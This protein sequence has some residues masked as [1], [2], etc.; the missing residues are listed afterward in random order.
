MKKLLFF[1]VSVCI[2]LQVNS[3]VSNDDCVNATPITIPA[4][5]SVCVTGTTANALGT[6]YTSHGCYPTLQNIPDVW[7]TFI[8]TGQQNVFTLSPNG[9]T[10]AQQVGLTISDFPCSSASS[11]ACDMSATNNGT[12][13]LTYIYPVGTQVWINISSIVAQGGFNLCITL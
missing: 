3:Q 8:A 6:T 10:P 11:S 1:I 2:S 9:A 13:N 12:A 5:G 4:S 7:Y